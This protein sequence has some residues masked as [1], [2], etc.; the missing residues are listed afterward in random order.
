M[1]SRKPRKRLLWPVT[2]AVLLAGAAGLFW[3][4]GRAA[5]A[6]SGGGGELPE[7]AAPSP[8]PEP[9]APMAVGGVEIVA[10]ESG[11]RLRG[12]ARVAAEW[13]G[14][15]GYAIFRVDDQFMYA[16]TPP[17]EMRWDTST[18]P[19]GK[20]IITVDAYDPSARYA[21]SSSIS[22]IVENSIPTPPEGV[23]LA[24]HF[25]EHD[26][27]NRHISA[28]G[29]LEALRADEALPEGFEVLSGELRCD[30]SQS[31]LDTFYQGTSTLIRNRVRS[32]S[33][34]V[35]GTRR[36]IPEDGRYAIVQVSP[37]GLALPESTGGSRPRIGIGEISLSL[38][39]YPVLPGDTWQKPMGVVCELY[40]R[41]GVFLQGSHT[42]EGLRWFRG[43]ECAVITS[44]YALAELPL[45]GRAS[46]L[47][48]AGASL[49]PSYRI[50]LTQRRRSMRGRPGMRGGRRGPTGGARAQQR[51]GP[52]AAPAAPGRPAGQANLGAL[53]RVRL[54]DL[55]G[56]RRTYLERDTGRILHMEDTILGKIQ[57]QVSATQTA[58]APGA[59]AYALELTQMRGRRGGMGMR[60]GGR[61]G[62]GRP[63]MMRGG[64]LGSGARAPGAAPGR[65]AGVQAGTNIPPRLN[66]GFRLTMDLEE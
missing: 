56:S 63:G 49:P 6:L 12:L 2:L 66:Y 11:A 65:P 52:A 35:A 51:R 25:D 3:T 22:V 54:L 42:F 50:E 21:G 46:R 8:E 15:R 14:G 26:Q 60:G 37:N 36:T 53:E 16:T 28:R 19:D 44:S 57:F 41:R 62:G 55:E 29:E 31:V 20:H 13:P 61:R 23:L 39:D 27:L 24:V 30:L 1:D 5:L 40:T 48:G 59:S 58:S 33:L 10:P 64:R 17:Y 4:T 47:A 45:F 34:I 7:F 38:A 43:R 32:G 9:D 18:A